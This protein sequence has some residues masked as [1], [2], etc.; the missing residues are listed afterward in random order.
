MAGNKQAFAPQVRSFDLNRASI[1]EDARTVDVIFSTETDQVERWFGREILDHGPKSVRMGRLKNR[2]AVLWNH[3]SDKV[4]GVVESATI[5]GKQGAATLRISRSED[6]EEL[7]SEIK[8]GIISKVSFG[9]R[10]HGLVLESSDAKTGTDTYRVTDWEPFEISF[11]SI[12]ADD[13]AGVR[14]QSAESIFGQRAAELTTYI[15]MSKPEDN[16]RATDPETPSVPVASNPETPETGNRAAVIPALTEAE[17][18]ARAKALA[19]EQT[20]A[21]L[22]RIDEIRA[23][24]ERAGIPAAEIEKA[25]KDGETVEAFKARTF[26]ILAAKNPPI[27][28]PRAMESSENQLK[29]GTRVHTVTTWAESAKRSLGELGKRLEIP[30]YSREFTAQ[31]RE[32][33]G[34]SEKVR[35]HRSLNG[36]ITLIDKIQIDEGIGAPVVVE[37]VSQAP[38]MS[39]FPV[40][41]ISGDTV[42]LSVRTGNPTVGFRDANSGRTGK[43]GTFESR[44]FQ[45]KVIEEPIEIDIQGVLRASKDPGRLLMAETAS[46]T[47]AVLAH[48]AYQSYYGGT[49]QANVDAK[50]APG[51]I[52]QSNSATTH[53]VD[54]T[55]S[56]AKTS[57]WLVEL[58]NGSLDHIYGN[59]S[60]LTY[61]ENWI[62]TVSEDSDGGKLRVLQNWISGRFALRLSNK[63][64][65]IRIKNIGT[66]SGKGLTDVLLASALRKARELG[67][68]PNAIMLNPRSGEQLQTSRTTYSPIGAPAPLPEEYQGIPFYYT[69]NI[70][71]AETV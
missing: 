60:T 59:D 64:A 16:N 9:Y 61:N 63:N 65:A 6:G 71:N 70:S 23:I 50:A 31:N 43:K 57:V 32:Y 15:A 44:V 20:R 51:L 56:T 4:R 25:K 36:A 10:V 58:G 17:I 28:T 12:P 69:I 7:W 22:A 34:G 40:D 11:V 39:I 35:M 18:E 42:T 26:D 13:S 5:S 55:G 48:C 24:G 68:R 3:D 19:T 27:S 53:V 52:A 14:T 66:D 30:D 46:V 41:I 38:E 62:E 67:M 2:A 49:A 29:R 47:E 21:E 8:D 45:T 54:A 37:A 33:V 1:N